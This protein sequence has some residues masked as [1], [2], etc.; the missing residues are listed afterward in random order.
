MSW[1]IIKNLKA[2]NGKISCEMRSNKVR[3][4]DYYNGESEDTTATGARVRR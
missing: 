4:P 1:Q 3:P 2:E